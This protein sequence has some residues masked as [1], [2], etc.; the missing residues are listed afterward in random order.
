MTVDELVAYHGQV[1]KNI[2]EADTEIQLLQKDE[3]LTQQVN[4]DLERQVGKVQVERNKFAE[5]ILKL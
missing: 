5:D 1:T 3:V 4:Y 2:Q